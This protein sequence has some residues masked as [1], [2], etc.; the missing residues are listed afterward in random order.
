MMH[1]HANPE[2]RNQRAASA[3][4]SRAH[5]SEA[6][7]KAKG[8]GTGAGT[9]GKSNL[10]GHIIPVYGFGILL[11]ILYILFKITSKGSSQPP[12]GRFS[13]VHAEKTKRKITDYE[14]AQLQ[15]KLRETEMVMENIVSSAHHSTDRVKGVTAD[16]EESLL[17][18]LTEITRVMREGQLVDGVSP[19]NKVQE[20]W[21][22]FPEEPQRN[23]DHS[24]CCCQHSPQTETEAEA[25]D[26]DLMENIPAEDIK[27]RVDPEEE[28]GK[29][30]T[31]GH[32]ADVELES[33]QQVI[34][35][36]ERHEEEERGATVDLDLPEE[37]NGILEEVELTP[38]MGSMMKPEKMENLIRPVE[39]EPAVRRRN[40]RRIKKASQ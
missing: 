1:R 2:A 7:A 35:S 19:E 36:V 30:V 23:W 39:M 16:Q 10:A 22:G 33:N 9:G 29:L 3:G 21:G 31:E 5:N 20:D 8:G 13:S 37:M 12:E 15:E 34:E 38:N 11:Y 25:A 4:Y 18:Q 27:G 17:Q 24:H 32:E 6:V 40:K 28:E 14:L 26:S